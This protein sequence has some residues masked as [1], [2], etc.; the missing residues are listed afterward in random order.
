MSFKIPITKRAWYT[1]I[2]ACYEL[3]CDNKS[4]VL[5]YHSRALKLTLA[6]FAFNINF[7]YW[8]KIASI[9]RGSAKYDVIT[10]LADGTI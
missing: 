3:H 7:S 2:H 8:S 1:C 4:K 9:M 6:Q 10:I 5:L